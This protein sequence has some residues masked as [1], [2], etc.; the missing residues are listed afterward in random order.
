MNIVKNPK[1]VATIATVLCVASLFWLVTTQRVNHSLETDLEHEKLRSEALLS[2]KLLLE[3]DI[4]KMKTQLSGLKGL[5]GDLDILVRNTEA[6]FAEQE[7]E[8]K[9]LRSA[10]ASL[11][12]VRKQ[13]EQLL[14]IQ[15]ELERELQAMRGS[16]SELERENQTLSSTIAQLQDQNQLLMADLNRAMIASIDHSQVQAVKGR[17][18]RLTVR[19]RKTNKL[20]ADFEVPGSLRNISYRIL[21]PKGNPL[22]E[23]QGVIVSHATPSGDHVL[24][25]AGDGT[26]GNGLQKVRMEYLPKVKLQSGV[27]TVEI[28]NDNLYVGSMNV[29]LR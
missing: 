15:Q 13:R 5:N 17:K 8:M 27:Y 20:I 9:K 18:D 2:E 10:N 1:A 25:S 6:K 3:K 29:K 21:D 22:T 7:A 12:L 14:S 28:L 19:A 24:A 26:L 4:E 11:A 16:L 23:K